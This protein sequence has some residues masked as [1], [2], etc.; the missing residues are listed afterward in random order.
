MAQSDSEPRII[1]IQVGMPRQ[2][3]SADAARA[4][5]RPWTS[6]IFKRPVD[7]PVHVCRTNLAGD[8]QAD[9]VHHGG[10]DK[11][12]LAYSADHYELWRAELGFDEPPCEG[13]RDV[14]C[15]TGTEVAARC[16]ALGTLYCEAILAERPCRHNATFATI[17]RSL[18][19]EN[20]R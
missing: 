16:K 12:V 20:F 13:A 6:G 8:G 17:A 19:V 1:S 3:G 15:E 10:I 7:G 14:H 4:E 9:P 11:A 18:T 5:D 2:F